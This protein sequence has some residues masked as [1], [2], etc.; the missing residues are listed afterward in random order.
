MCAIIN[1][2]THNTH[3]PARTHARTR[4]R[5]RTHTHTHTHMHTQACMHAQRITAPKKKK[6]QKE[7]KTLCYTVSGLERTTSSNGSQGKQ[8][9]EMKT[10]NK[11]SVDRSLH[12][13]AGTLLPEYMTCTGRR[14]GH[15]GCLETVVLVSMEPH[16]DAPDRSTLLNE[17][18]FQ[19]RSTVSK[20]RFI[21]VE[22]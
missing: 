20:F 3:S 9:S 15:M 13:L 2:D 21:V 4:A 7:T 6:G 17:L 22:D 10:K 8:T 16:T 5:T 11:I 18:E 1:V 19:T 12:P 14:E